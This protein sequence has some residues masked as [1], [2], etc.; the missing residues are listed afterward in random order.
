MMQINLKNKYR[1]L[2]T[3]VLPYEVPLMFDNYEFY[4][5]IID[6]KKS[7]IFFEQ[8]NLMRNGNRKENWYIPFNYTVR[9]YGGGSRYLSIMHPLNQLDVACFYDKY[10]DYMLYLCSRSPFSIRYINQVSKCI[11]DVEND[12]VSEMDENDEEEEVYKEYRSYFVYEKYYQYY[13]FF[14]G[15][16]Q[17]R[18]EQKYKYCMKLDIAKCF[19]HIYTH[20]IAWAI[21]GKEY[22]KDNIGSDSLECNFD[23]MMQKCNYNETNGIIVGPEVSRIFAEIILQ[24][25]DLN[26]LEELKKDNVI[27][28][29]DYDVRR[30]VDDY[31][32]FVNDEKK[33]E[34]IKKVCE[35]QCEP[36]KMY[37]NE[38]KVKVLTRPFSTDISSAKN[39]VEKLIIEM[40][41]EYFTKNEVGE[42]KKKFSDVPK[43]LVKFVHRISSI[44]HQNNVD[45]SEINRYALFLIK[46]IVNSELEKNAEPS[47]G[48]ILSM[49]EISFYLFSLDM[50]VSGSVKIS[51][52]VD[53]IVKWSKKISD[54]CVR[55]KIMD[56][57]Y[58]E[59]K[60]CLDV[61][62]TTSK[63]NQTNLEI[64]NLLLVLRRNTE[65]EIN[66]DLIRSIFDLETSIEN[67][68]GFEK[69]NYFQICTIL[70]VLENSDIGIYSA[71]MKEV[72]RKFNEK[73]FP[74][75]DSE[76][77]LLYF[78]MLTCPYLN[79]NTKL[80]IYACAQKVEITPRKK[81]EYLNKVRRVNKVKRWFFDWDKNRDLSFIIGKKEHFPAYQ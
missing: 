58:R 12:N 68:K 36:Y 43:G 53:L 24:R 30:Y 70:Y 11:F 40:E 4:Q 26:I 59:S 15:I 78:D 81:I 61:Y 77:T 38:K 49:M 67:D 5:N 72:K 27:L 14:E 79:E 7:K 13:K 73:K 31:L 19:Y 10:A 55:Q 54:V 62:N 39:E 28:G 35:K 57:L 32:I 50:T 1:V 80:E 63:T 47:E 8:F 52:L 16:D 33:L 48:Q 44:A 42:Y 66:G 29:K 76:L 56:R 22:A 9:K 71:L 21:K 2:L 23:N 45:Y 17:V 75:S 64:L 3:E 41:E 69:L 46:K 18:L 60:R 25:I 37:I 6:E 34:K 51:R 74:L 20:S 65:F